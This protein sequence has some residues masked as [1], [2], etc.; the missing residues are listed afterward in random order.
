MGTD[1]DPFPLLMA[2]PRCDIWIWN[3]IKPLIVKVKKRK[4]IFEKAH[5]KLFPFP[6]FVNQKTFCEE[7]VSHMSLRLQLKILD[8]PLL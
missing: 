3:I 5:E 4:V 8:S 1:A 2:I 7:H 6:C